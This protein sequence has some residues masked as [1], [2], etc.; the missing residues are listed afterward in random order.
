MD[1]AAIP[2]LMGQTVGRREVGGR[3]LG[4]VSPHAETHDI[5]MRLD[6]HGLDHG[7]RAFGPEMADADDDDAA[8]DAEVAPGTV[9]AVGQGLEPGGVGNAQCRRTLG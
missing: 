4:L 7:Q 5:G 9:D 3:E 1:G 2:A 8:H 6:D